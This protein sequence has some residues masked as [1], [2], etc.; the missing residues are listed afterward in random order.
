MSFT[1]ASSDTCYVISLNSDCWVLWLCLPNICKAMRLELWIDPR[2]GIAFCML[3]QEKSQ[4]VE[5][6]M[7]LY[8]GQNSLIDLAEP[9]QSSRAFQ[10]TPSVHLPLDM[11]VVPLVSKA[12]Y[13]P[14]KPGCV[15]ST[16]ALCFSQYLHYLTSLQ[17]MHILRGQWSKSSVEKAPGEGTEGS[18]YHC[19]LLS[20]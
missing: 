16:L 1:H 20:Q 15:W 10:R 14:G 3:L 19:L 13:K 2:Q 8:G 18:R 17:D 4:I 5:D 12:L 6:W 11:V 7:Q 9:T